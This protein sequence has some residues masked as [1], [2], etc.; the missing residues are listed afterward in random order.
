MIRAN[1]AAIR[2]TDLINEIKKC[3]LEVSFGSILSEG[4]AVKGNIKE[5]HKSNSSTNSSESTF[6]YEH[7]LDTNLRNCKAKCKINNIINN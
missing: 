7:T 4:N 1:P 2:I 5:R 6:A 3:F